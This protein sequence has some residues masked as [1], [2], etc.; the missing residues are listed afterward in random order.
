MDASKILE[1][2]TPWPWEADCTT[3][4]DTGV[5]D[6][7]VYQAQE[8]HTG[9]KLGPGEWSFIVRDA[10]LSEAE[11]RLIAKAPEMYVLLREAAEGRDIATKARKMVEQMEMSMSNNRRNADDGA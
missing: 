8:L 1:G 5:R 2:I 4:I 9:Q 7:E 6:W 11:A 10:L 3:D